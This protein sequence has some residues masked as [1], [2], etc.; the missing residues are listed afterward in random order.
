MTLPEGEYGPQ[1]WSMQTFQDG[2]INSY[3]LLILLAI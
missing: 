3:R 2:M 1:L